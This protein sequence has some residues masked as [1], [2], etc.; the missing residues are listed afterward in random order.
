MRNVLQYNFSDFQRGMWQEIFFCL[1]MFFF[2]QGKFI[3]KCER[4]D[5]F[6]IDIN[7]AKQN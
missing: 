1:L 4:Y 5:I 7:Y 2:V 3:Y 6:I